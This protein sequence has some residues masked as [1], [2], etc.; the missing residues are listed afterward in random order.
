MMYMFTETLTA[1][2]TQKALANVPVGV[3]AD[4]FT[5]SH[6]GDAICE[7][8]TQFDNNDMLEKVKLT[9][10]TTDT[11]PSGVRHQ[12]GERQAVSYRCCRTS[13]SCRQ[14]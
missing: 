5:V 10:S 7:L 4:T 3:F 1:S 9:F 6:T 11:P 12:H 13:L 8:E 2:I 14:G